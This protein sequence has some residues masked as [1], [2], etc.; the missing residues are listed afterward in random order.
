MIPVADCT[1]ADCVK[2]F[3]GLYRDV[4][5]ALA[6]ELATLAGEFGVDVAEELVDRG[7]TVYAVDPV[8]TTNP[9]DGV[10]R[11][12]LDE[13]GERELDLA[14]VT[15]GHEAFA[16]IPWS[17]F[18]DITIVDS[19]QFLDERSVAHPVVRLGDGADRR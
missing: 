11:V 5:I 14:V 12:S 15:T 13:I 6:N 17:A 18:E 1:T 19:R 9:P 8:C 7:T 10:D 4:N 16:E 2:V 3:E